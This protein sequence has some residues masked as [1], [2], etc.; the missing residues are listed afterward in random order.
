MHLS[1][2]ARLFDV[3]ALLVAGVDVIVG[4]LEVDRASNADRLVRRFTSL[5]YIWRSLIPR[6]CPRDDV[7]D[8]SNSPGCPLIV[9]R[10]PNRDTGRKC[11]VG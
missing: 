7:S 2:T 4:H 3:D 1:T 9:V 8:D 6:R 10:I 11:S 5:R